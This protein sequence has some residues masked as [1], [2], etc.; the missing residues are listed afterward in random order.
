MQ[1]Y[2]YRDQL[3]FSTSCN[4][5]NLLRTLLLAHAFSSLFC[6]S[7]EC[8]SLNTGTFPGKIQINATSWVNLLSGF[9]MK[10]MKGIITGRVWPGSSRPQLCCI[11]EA[12]WQASW[13]KCKLRAAVASQVVAGGRAK[14]NW[15]SW[16]ADNISTEACMQKSDKQEV[17]SFTSVILFILIVQQNI[18]TSDFLQKQPRLPVAR[19]INPTL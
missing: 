16:P 11:Q 4:W 13:V 15:E 18:C 3:V 7:P 8:H 12:I 2:I 6:P 14:I 10:Y 1:H 9:E 5:G 17:R 19:W